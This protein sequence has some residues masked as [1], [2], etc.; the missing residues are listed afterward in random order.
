MEG[1]V[2]PG[3]SASPNMSHLDSVSVLSQSEPE[4]FSH[5]HLYVCA[6]FLLRWRKEILGERDFQVRHPLH[7]AH[8]RASPATALARPHLSALALGYMCVWL[9]MIICV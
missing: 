1:L 7:C 4:G 8:H 9:R 5:F 2:A 3:C 6:A